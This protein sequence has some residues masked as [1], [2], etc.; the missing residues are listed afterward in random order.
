MRELPVP[1][2]FD[3]ASVERVARV[4]YQERWREAR[5]WAAAHGLQ[6][7]ARDR[8][9]VGLLAVDLQN[10]FCLPQSELFVAGRSGRGAMDDNARLCRFIYRN[11]AILTEVA[12]TLDTHEA[13]QIFHPPFWVDG[14]G[15]HPEPYT[16]ISAADVENGTWRPNPD[17]A[18]A[19]DCDPA[20]LERH[21]LHYVRALAGRYPLM[22][23]PFHSML[24]GVG[25]A[26]VAGVEEAF[27][28]HSVARTAR[29][30][31][32]LKG[33]HPLTENYSVLRP[34]VLESPD[35]RTIG[36]RN[37]A[38]LDMLLSYD[39][40]IVAG[41]AKSHCVAWTMDDLL[42][43]IRTR[44]QGAAAARVPRI[45]LLEDCMSPVVVPGADFTDAAEETFARL[46]AAGMHRV[47]S[48][49]APALWP[50]FPRP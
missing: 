16:Q 48:T 10:T 3:P 36:R 21:A 44:T 17:A 24:G 34:E 28:F 15:E 45:Y 2:F 5:A 22:I 38:F 42:S 12:A 40:L 23:W 20:H 25:H 18:A 9:R 30:R 26:L 33:R 49:D 4:P 50:E 19:L 27:F 39:A 35:G 29:T 11:L 31:F 41:Q 6:P 43:E 8:V 37:T 32:E 46:Q 14:R 1:D 7:A 13:L 47:R